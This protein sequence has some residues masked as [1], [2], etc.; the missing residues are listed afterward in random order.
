MSGKIYLSETIA[1]DKEEAG[2]TLVLPEDNEADGLVIFLN[3]NREAG[4]EVEAPSIDYY[5]LQ[6]NLGM[7]YITTGNR[8]EFFFEKEKLDQVD[9]Y[10]AEIVEE[11][12]IPKENLFFG[13]MSLAGTRALK[14]AIYCAKGNSKN[15]LMPKAIAACDSPLD[16]IRFWRET[17]KAK[18]IA[19]NP[20]TQNEGEWVS[21]YLEKNLGGTPTESLQ[22]Y[23]DY[24]VYCYRP[25][26]G[27]N[28]DYLKDIAVRAYT[29]P[30]VKWWMKTRGKDYYAMNAVDLAG[31]INYL[32]IIGNDKAEL[33]ITNDK[34]YHPD[35]TRHPHSWSI[36]DNKELVEWFLNSMEGIES[37][38]S[39]RNK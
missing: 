21:S 33:V 28:T 1:I 19:F 36:V 34:G 18:R 39:L 13:G 7:L 22:S 26:E 6:N 17:D 12:K 4:K 3:G 16:M 32:N 15:G 10:I 14:Y 30:D 35:G 9:N 24:S 11:Y 29:E 25:E 37:E 38:Q 23:Q 8:L 27:C 31:M 5:A 20:I 2:Y